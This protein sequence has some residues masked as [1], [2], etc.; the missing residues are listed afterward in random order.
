M[1]KLAAEMAALT[2]SPTI[3]PSPVI[4]AMTSGRAWYLVEKVMSSA[5]LV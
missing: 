5:Y 1:L 3:T 4:R 2:L